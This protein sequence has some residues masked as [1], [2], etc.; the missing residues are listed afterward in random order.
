MKLFAEH[1]DD[2]VA[3]VSEDFYGLS[4]LDEVQESSEDNFFLLLGSQEEEDHPLVRLIA[5]TD[6]RKKLKR[7]QDSDPII[8]EVKCF[9][10]RRC[11][12][13]SQ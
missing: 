9:V 7:C 8:S 3:E 1:E 12:N 10:K 4:F 5:E 2:E 13:I 6:A 11:S